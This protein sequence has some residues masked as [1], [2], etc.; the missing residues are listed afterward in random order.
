M[1]DIAHIGLVDAHAKRA[2]GNHAL[3]FSAV[4][5]VHRR[6]ILFGRARILGTRFSRS[7]VLVNVFQAKE[8]IIF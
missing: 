4:P 8:L 5:F 3:D 7:V 2:R 6:G 1:H